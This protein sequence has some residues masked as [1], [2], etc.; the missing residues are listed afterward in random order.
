M[1]KDKRIEEELE[2]DGVVKGK[3]HCQKK[4]ECTREGFVA[5]NGYKERE[6]DA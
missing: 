1:Q 6:L 4:G 5:E 2:M 3:S